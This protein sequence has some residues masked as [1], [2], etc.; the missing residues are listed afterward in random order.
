MQWTGREKAAYSLEQAFIF[1]GVHYDSIKLTIA[2]IFNCFAGWLYTTFT[3]SQGKQ[4]RD[5]KIF[6]KEGSKHTCI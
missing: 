2:M 5:G 1:T 4:N 6:S 3:G